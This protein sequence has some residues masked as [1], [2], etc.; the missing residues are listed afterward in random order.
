MSK[1]KIVI[2]RMAHADLNKG[3][4]VLLASILQSLALI[5]DFDITVISDFPEKVRAI[6]KV[7]AVRAGLKN[8]IEVM[9]TIRQA[10]FFIWGGGHMLQDQSSSLDVPFHLWRVFFAK[11]VGVPVI[12]YAV[13]I[14]P[15]QTRIG[16]F[17]ARIGLGITDLIIVRDEN[18]KFVIEKLGVNNRRVHIAAD[19]AFLVNPDDAIVDKI[20]Q[21]Y[22]IKNGKPLVAIAPRKAFYKVSG[23]LPATIRIKF[24]LMPH[25]FYR[26]YP[27]FKK[28][29]A[30]LCDYL[31]SKFGVQIILLPMDV[32]SNPRDD[33]V[34]K[35]IFELM[36]HKDSALV[37]TDEL[38]ASET[39]GLIKKMDLVIS[40]RLHALILSSSMNVPMLA[41]ASTNKYDKCRKFMENINQNKRCIDAENVVDD[42]RNDSIFKLIDNTWESRSQI[43]KELESEINLL[44]ERAS[45]SANLMDSF[46]S[47]RK[48]E[49]ILSK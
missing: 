32:A 15:L 7:R 2:A 27:A 36:S 34:C 45:L 25:I 29:I 14:G 3:E 13:G 12:L 22:M 46:L 41:I 40:Q 20:K 47:N 37:L 19:P 30:V 6:H 38:S 18:S 44:K 23:F 42:A 11:M 49:E 24:N 28:Q 9:M 33:L 39:A 1:S 16:R 8:I 17:F 26:K 4:E 35:E 5:G 43:Q 48:R 21:K 31:I 10:D